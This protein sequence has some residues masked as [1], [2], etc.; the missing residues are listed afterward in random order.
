MKLIKT[1]VK[2]PV[3]VIMIVLAILALGTISLRNL[4]VDLFPEIDLPIAVVATSYQDAAPEEVENLIS[5]PIESSVSSVE[6][7]QTVQSQSQAGSSLV[8]MM[9]DTGTNLDQALLNVRESI[10]QVKGMLPED[11]GDPSVL[12]F[13]P[14]QM[15]IMWVGLTG[16]EASKLTQ[17]ADNQ[18]VPFFERQGGVASVT[19]E[20]AENREIQLIL[21]QAKLQQYGVNAQTITQALNSSSQSSSAGVVE[22]GAQ[23]LQLRVTGGF[24]SVEAIENTLVQTQTG[25]T[26][27]ID[28]LA[29]VKDTFTDS[30]GETL[31]NGDQAVVLSIMKQTDANTVEVA[32]NINDS[33]EEIEGELPSGLSTDVVVDTSEY[34]NM[35]IKSVAQNILIGGVISFLI[36]LLFLKSLR[37]TIVIGLSI[38]IAIISTFTLM[39]FTGE[40]L[41]VLT[42]GGLALGLGM[43]VDS[44]IVILEH[45]YSYR[46]RGY[47]L[48][49]SAIKGA[50]EL[51][52]AVI[53][54]TTTTL[55]VFLPMVF[56]DGIASDMFTPLALTV[57]FALIASLVAAV[58]LVPMLSSKLLA[59][60]TRDSGKRYWFN[61]LLDRVNNVYQAVLKWALGHRKSTVFGTLLIIAGSLALI[62][63]IGA[64][65]MPSSDQ[66]QLQ[67]NVET[68]PGSS[69]EHT[70]S[71][72][73]NVNEKMSSYEDVIE[74]NYMNVGGGGGGAP[75]MGGSSNQA[76]YMMQLVPASDRSQTTDD[77]VQ[78]MSDELASVPGAE[79]SVT[80]TDSG[81]GMG[82]P[83]QIS[84]SGPEHEVLRELSQEVVDTISE[85]DGVHNAST[86]AD[87]SAPQMH[88]E[89][90]SEKAAMYG[91]TDQ[92]ITSQIQLQFTGQTAA[93]YREDGDEMDIT[94]M[95]PEEQRSTINDLENVTIQSESGAAVPLTTLATLDQ[96][97]G[98]VTLQR[99]NQQPQ[100]NVTSE[101]I[102]RDLGS[103][104]SDIRE[105]LNNMAMPEEYNYEIGGQAEDMAS[106]FRDLS[107]ALV[108]SIFLVYAVMAVQFENFLFPLIIMF[109]L[110]ATVVG[111]LLGLLVTGLPLSIPA[112]IGIIMLVGIVVNNSIV[113]VDYIN[114][115]RREEYGKGRYEAI[116][117]AGASRLRPIL[118]TTLTTILAMVPLGLALGEGAEMQQPL[119]V[120][121]IF[122]LTVSS[123]FTLVLIPV[124]YTLFDDLTAKITRR[125]KKA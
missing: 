79:I 106:S 82:D 71:V 58:T 99:E 89:V 11:A 101:I 75:G 1:S 44:S 94:L 95:Y 74:T 47:S 9:F 3:G 2:R 68:Q 113:L 105:K 112:F 15:P 73:E 65:F 103:I 114:I 118:M 23:D 36:L 55:V 38:P 115:L 32:N 104:T 122:G 61:R 123:I 92:Q 102:G 93:Q 67:V 26:V 110:P 13:N 4:N 78:S 43:M 40:T 37:A 30:S 34:I 21:D 111:V 59:K 97:E 8:M 60:A 35:S 85:V 96:V 72:A 80:A 62:P 17:V 98:P 25:E 84:L 53:A 108:F 45:I 76:T 81:A 88:I 125:G 124:V 16:D 70:Q 119:A 42:L 90:D 52:P 57:S 66:G 27:H 50:S 24:D 20:G 6:G 39:Y 14:N 69:L 22:K 116:L 29:N 33:M 83:V 109:S 64:S 91:L 121:I 107:I 46:Q 77:V 120:T 100:L 86:S 10:D 56:V 19:V 54:S 51:A 12:R 63:M 117:E 28:E 41:N 18:V 7:I 5:R 87:D 49:Q 31:V 48:T